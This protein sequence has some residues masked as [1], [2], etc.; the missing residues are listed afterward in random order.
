MRVESPDTGQSG[1]DWCCGRQ[2]RQALCLQSRLRACSCPPQ[3]SRSF[4]DY[5]LMKLSRWPLAVALAPS[6]A[7]AAND[8]L[9]AVTELPPLVITRATALQAPAPASV[10]VID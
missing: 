2:H 10:A 3:K 8:D 6:L 1:F 5:L 7:L 4:E 9:P